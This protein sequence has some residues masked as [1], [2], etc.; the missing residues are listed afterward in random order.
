M[1]NSL[2]CV[3]ITFNILR[4]IETRRTKVLIRPNVGNSRRTREKTSPGASVFS[5]ER[6]LSWSRETVSDM[7]ESRKSR[8]VKTRGRVRPWKVHTR[9]REE[10]RACLSSLFRSAKPLL[11]SDRGWQNAPRDI[12]DDRFARRGDHAIREN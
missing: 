1:Y 5:G 3:L 8:S 2:F 6:T 4:K 10:T 7:R 11:S 12:D 9:E